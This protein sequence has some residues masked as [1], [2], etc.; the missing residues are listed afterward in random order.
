MFSIR[1][2]SLPSN[3]IPVDDDSPVAV[4]GLCRGLVQR[5]KAEDNDGEEAQIHEACILDPTCI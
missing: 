1:M 2:R 5:R 4:E 3:R